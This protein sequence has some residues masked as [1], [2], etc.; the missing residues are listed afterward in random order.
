MALVS[1]LTAAR[2]SG[3]APV[4]KRS[5]TTRLE[6]WERGAARGHVDYAAGAE[7]F[8]LEGAFEDEYGRHGVGT[9][10][11]LPAGSRHLPVPSED[12]V[13]YIKEGGFSYLKG[14]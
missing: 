6:R 7:L 9:W 14:G 10:L 5:S 12:C 3:V 1:W 13:L 8:V 4:V 11:R 2:R